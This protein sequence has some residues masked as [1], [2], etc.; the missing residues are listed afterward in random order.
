MIF[1]IVILTF[2]FDWY[3]ILKN[4]Q[5]FSMSRSYRTIRFKIVFDVCACQSIAV[6]ACFFRAV[7][8]LVSFVYLSL[9]C[10]LVVVLLV[11][12]IFLDTFPRRALPD[13]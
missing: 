2:M 8:K 6:L 1:A 12:L 13:Q 11:P 5:S 3:G 7:G 10:L 9:I 4:Q